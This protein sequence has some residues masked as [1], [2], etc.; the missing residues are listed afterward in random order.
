MI[1][2]DM[3]T[4]PEFLQSFGVC[5]FLA[6]SDHVLNEVL[7]LGSFEACLR[8]PANPVFKWS[9]SGTLSFLAAKKLV[10]GVIIPGDS[11]R[12]PLWDGE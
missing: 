10:T 2:Q 8:A 4:P 5:L 12:D 1:R 11:S 7:H 6:R 3:K 9:D